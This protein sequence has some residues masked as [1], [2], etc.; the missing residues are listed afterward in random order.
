VL[1]ARNQRALTDTVLLC[2]TSVDIA[3]ESGNVSDEEFAVGV[4]ARTV[5]R[6]GERGH[7]LVVHYMTE[8]KT[9]RPY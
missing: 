5:E 3:V 1:V 4:F 8:I 9:A 7:L 6:F 2:S